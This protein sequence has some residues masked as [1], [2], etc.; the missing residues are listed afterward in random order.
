MNQ[1]IKTIL[2]VAT[3]TYLVSSITLASSN[4]DVLVRVEPRYPAEAIRNSIQGWCEIE[5]SISET[6][7][8]QNVTAK[9]CSDS[10]LFE[11]ESVKA[12]QRWLYKPM[13]EN[14][15]PQAI[16]GVRER[17]VFDLGL[18]EE[19]AE[20]AA[21]QYY[22]F[23]TNEPA[24][25]LRNAACQLDKAMVDDLIQM[26]ANVN[27][28][29]EYR[30]SILAKIGRCEHTLKKLGK[31][32][33]FNQKYNEILHS[34]FDSGLKIPGFDTGV[35]LAIEL[36]A[37]SKNLEGVLLILKNT[38]GN[39]SRF[40]KKFDKNLLSRTFPEKAEFFNE[41]EGVGYQRA[42]ENEIERKAEKEQQLI[43]WE[44]R[45]KQIRQFIQSNPTL[46]NGMQDVADLGSY[47]K[48]VKN[49]DIEIYDF[50]CAG[51]SSRYRRLFESP[52][53][54][55][56]KEQ[57]E[58]LTQKDVKQSCDAYEQAQQS[59]SELFGEYALIAQELIDEAQGKQHD[60]REYEQ[61]LSDLEDMVQEAKDRADQE[62][63]AQHRSNWDSFAAKVSSIGTTETTI[64]R[65]FN[66]HQRT[67]RDL[68]Q[69]KT[70]ST[71][72]VSEQDFR[73]LKSSLDNINLKATVSTPS[74][75]QLLAEAESKCTSQGGQFYVN[76]Q[77]NNHNCVITHSGKNSA[78]G[79]PAQMVGTTHAVTGSASTSRNSSA[80][81][82]RTSTSMASA[83]A[84]QGQTSSLPAGAETIKVK[85]AKAICFKR[86]ESG[87]PEGWK[88]IGPA[89]NATQLF[90]HT[91]TEA[92]YSVRCSN[93]RKRV[94]NVRGDYRNF[95]TVDY[96]HIAYG[97][98]KPLDHGNIDIDEMLQIKWPADAVF[99]EYTCPK[100][101]ARN[102]ENCPF[103]EVKN[104]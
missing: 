87:K 94:H 102:V 7:S 63:D 30:T 15:A 92:L 57:L 37:E 100:F 41:V 31:T 9:K 18:S 61:A 54:E 28:L 38:D 75:A 98:G 21:T 77:N 33:E 35:E 67:L 12:V 101:G 89:Q 83:M 34:L 71:Y 1:R 80:N 17:I 78:T 6:G 26:D 42:L 51:L 44:L 76:R 22:H 43:A 5:F 55:A 104:I 73:K 64:N 97:C 10:N 59:Y 25:N 79:L 82:S 19:D 27:Y 66:E 91:E 60:L 20:R 62:D 14:G 11:T 72:N 85:E 65:M 96:V 24:I 39:D 2:S 70:P 68:S 52:A 48:S 8:T 13:I 53:C 47:C 29:D 46:T 58:S 4:P 88:C 49:F 90:A 50:E 32:E 16:G 23:K 86:V 69:R 81:A 40:Y 36:A 45:K 56:H 93:P 103:E 99:V 84:A 3:S 74:V 95:N